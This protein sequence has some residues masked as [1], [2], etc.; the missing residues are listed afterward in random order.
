MLCFSAAA[1]QHSE[2]SDNQTTTNSSG[3]ERNPSTLPLMLRA[4]G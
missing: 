2:G 1:S 3:G 4:E